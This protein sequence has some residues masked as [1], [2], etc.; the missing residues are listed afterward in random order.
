MWTDR[1]VGGKSIRPWL[2]WTSLGLIIEPP[3]KHL[4]RKLI[5]AGVDMA[6]V[7]DTKT[8]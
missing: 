8:T 4:A 2:T 1:N 6:G 3:R 5:V 7:R